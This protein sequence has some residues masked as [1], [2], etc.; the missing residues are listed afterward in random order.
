MAR[1]VAYDL[2]KFSSLLEESSIQGS[3][4]QWQRRIY[5][6]AMTM[7]C[8]MYGINLNVIEVSLSVGNHGTEE[9]ACV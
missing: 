3:A 7:I 5:L 2:S 6:K 9:G 1:V 4:M 8:L